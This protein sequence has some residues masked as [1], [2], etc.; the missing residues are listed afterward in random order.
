MRRPRGA[1]LTGETS[2]ESQGTAEGTLTYTLHAGVAQY[3]R[4]QQS[5]RVEAT[6]T[7]GMT[8]LDWTPPAAPFFK[9]TVLSERA[10]WDSNPRHE[11]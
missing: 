5:A 4:D 6:R 1:I 3:H 7:N 8:A 10:V 11:D 9:R 2:A